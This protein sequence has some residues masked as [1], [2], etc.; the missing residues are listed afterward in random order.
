MPQCLNVLRS[1]ALNPLIPSP[2]HT[3]GSEFVSNRSAF[4]FPPLPLNLLF[5]SKG[6]ENEPS[7]GRNELA[8]APSNFPERSASIC[9]GSL[10]TRDLPKPNWISGYSFVSYPIS[11]KNVILV[12]KHLLKICSLASFF[13]WRRVASG[14]RERRKG[15]PEVIQ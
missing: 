3:P 11:S 15:K 6:E 1:Y 7:E 12:S 9:I 5:Q 8:P 2:H 13:V 14:Q 4:G 10:R